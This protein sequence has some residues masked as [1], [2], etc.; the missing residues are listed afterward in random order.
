MQLSVPITPSPFY[1]FAPHRV[2]PPVTHQLAHQVQTQRG[3]SVNTA[4]VSGY[5]SSISRAIEEE[6]E[7]RKARAAVNR[8]G[9]D[10]EGYLVE[11][12][13]I[14]GQETCVI[15]PELKCAFDIGRCPSR[16]IQQKFLFITHAHLDHIGGLPMY[17]ASRGLYNLEPPKVFVPPSILEDVEN[18][19]EIHRSMGQ[20]ELNLELIPLDIGDTYE[21]R[22][23]IVVRPFRTNHVIPSQGYVVYSIRKKLKKQYA[24]LKGKQIEKIKKSGVEI[25]DTILSPEIAFTGDTTAE[26]ML[27]P[28]NADALRAKILITEATFLD[29]GFSIEHAQKHGHTHLSQLVENAKWIRSKAILLTH[30]SSRYH[31]EEIREATLKLQSKVSGKVVA[32]TEG[33]RSRYS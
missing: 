28:R 16:A 19:I 3:N 1:P 6:E 29:E 18:L 27:D 2:V 32:L 17:V 5:F 11:G 23:D 8:K 9:V 26:Y 25:T 12:V 33:F 13:S 20:V 22:N 14:G 15:V 7:Y 21:L 24:H 31:I 10:L 30:F 4:K